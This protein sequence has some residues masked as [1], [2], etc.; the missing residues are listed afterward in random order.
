MIQR[1]ESLQIE[2]CEVLET[3]QV[4]RK[5]LLHQDH[6]LLVNKRTGDKCIDIRARGKMT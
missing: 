6:L 1:K 3:S 5:Q 2:T 4:L